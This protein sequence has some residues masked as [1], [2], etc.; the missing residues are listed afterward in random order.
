MLDL[1]Y[2]EGPSSIA[3]TPPSPGMERGG[4]AALQAIRTAAAVAAKLAVTAACFWYFS[5][6]MTW[7]AFAEAAKVIDVRWS[8]AALALLTLQV[9]LAGIR[10]AEIVSV[11]APATP[12]SAR[13]QM[14]AI[15][16][17]GVFFG[18]IVPNL[19]GE[20]VRVFML[21]RLGVDWRTGLASVLIDRAIGVFAIV[22]LGFITFLVPSPLTSLGGHRSGL[23]LALGGLLAAGATGILIAGPL[24]AVLARRRLTFWL[25]QY[26]TMA[27][28]VLVRSRARASV[29]ALALAVH[30][31]T[32]AAIW[33][34]A[35]AGGLALSAAD[36]AALFTVIG[37]IAVI[38]VTIGGWGLREVGVTSLLQLQGVPVEQALV[39]SVSFGVM[40]FLAST[41]GAMA[42]LLYS[43][44]HAAGAV[45]HGK[46]RQTRAD[47]S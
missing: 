40:T 5:S 21:G 3:P 39:L 29:A 41:P 33:T 7:A 22:V 30:V 4:G 36:A 35:Q 28:E 6:R 11:L 19:F 18:Q 37:G 8:L 32:I 25:G 14:Q 34:L 31:L 12:R 1:L 43:P 17:I 13:P 46:V 27:H 15:T 23:L 47:A 16:W 10:W 44:R 38:P 26:A 9:P 45:T 2:E 42:W 24:G 20:T